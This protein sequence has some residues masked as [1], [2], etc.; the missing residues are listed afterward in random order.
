MP[1]M[2]PNQP[3]NRMTR[4]A[5]AGALTLL[6]VAGT[7]AALPIGLSH[8]VS[9]PAG[10]AYASYADDAAGVCLSP[11]TPALPA[12]PA[13]PL[14]L[15]VQAP[16]LPAASGA[17]TVCAD[18]SPDGVSVDASA[19]AAGLHAGAGAEADTSEQHESANGAIAAVKGFLGG[20]ADSIRS[21]F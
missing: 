7:A 2:A 21:W 1:Q 18:A 3:R 17:A 15:P 8:G 13:I 4:L 6:A 20:L 12:V 16:A 5:F 9:T 19:D 10:D 14:P 11:S